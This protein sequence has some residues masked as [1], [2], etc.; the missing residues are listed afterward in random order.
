MLNNV[1]RFN[2]IWRGLDKYA[3]VPAGGLLVRCCCLHECFLKSKAGSS[4]SQPHGHRPRVTAPRGSA[5]PN[6]SRSPQST[7]LFITYPPTPQHPPQS[8]V[9]SLAGGLS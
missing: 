5:T 1:F 9:E 6:P 7:T 3:N 8:L 4:C 2:F